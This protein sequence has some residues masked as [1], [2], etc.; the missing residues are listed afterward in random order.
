MKRQLEQA[1]HT[2][3]ERER[4][5]FILRYLQ[6]FSLQE[7]S[8]TVGIALGTVKAHLAHGTE[9]LKSILKEGVYHG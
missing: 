6:G 3:P 5:V 9:K 7:V 4:E 2:L 8:E 1:I